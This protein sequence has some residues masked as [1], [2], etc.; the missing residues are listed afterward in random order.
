MELPHPNISPEQRPDLE[1]FPFLRDYLNEVLRSLSNQL[2]Q[3]EADRSEFLLIVSNFMSEIR[4]RPILVLDI[5]NLEKFEKF[6][7]NF[8]EIEKSAG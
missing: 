3:G 5:K 6:I 2:K 7:L 1:N 4:K 8:R